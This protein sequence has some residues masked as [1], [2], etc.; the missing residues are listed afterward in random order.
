MG[1]SAEARR[2]PAIGWSLWALLF[3]CVLAIAI[4]PLFFVVNT[5]FYG[6]TQVGLSGLR[7]S[8][9]FMDVYT[10]ATY[11]G[12]MAN[13]LILAALVTLPSLIVGVALAVLVARTDLHGKAVWEMLIVLPLYLSPFTG[14]IAWIALGSAKTGFL[15]VAFR[16]LLA[17]FTAT[18]P[19]LFN[20]WTFGG[21]TL[22]MFLFFCP[23]VYLF[24]VGS[25]RAMDGSLEEAARTAGASPMQTILKITLPMSLPAILAAG[26][27]VFILSAEYYAIPGIIGATAGFTVLPWQIFLDST[28]FPVR[29]AHAAAAGTM[30][31]IIT[32]LGVWL[33]RRLTSRSERFVS[34]GGKGFADGR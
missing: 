25:L 24:T 11:L 6:E 33:Q 29:R 23:F 31:L 19:T 5:S 32:I 27:L 21:V 2:G 10:T 14:L 4:V 18:P 9:A 16:A 8:Q 30:L 12:E 3:A 15:N 7:S 34:I 13:A 26:L 17:P 22:V 28:A 1:N 20:V